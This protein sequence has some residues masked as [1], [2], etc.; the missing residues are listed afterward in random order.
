MTDIVPNDANDIDTGAN[1]F[2]RSSPRSA[3]RRE[4]SLSTT[5]STPGTI[6]EVFTNPSGKDIT[7]AGEA[8]VFENSA[9]IAQRVRTAVVPDSVHRRLG[10]RHSDAH[11]N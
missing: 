4:R 2:H 5:T 6:V 10:R 9:V 1:D 8:E 7:G 11:R 3:S